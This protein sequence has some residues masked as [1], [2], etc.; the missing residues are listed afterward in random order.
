MPVCE[1]DVHPLPVVISQRLV[2]QDGLSV[3]GG[4]DAVGSG[5]RAFGECGTLWQ[6]ALQERGDTSL[7]AGMT[8]SW[9]WTH[10]DVTVSIGFDPLGEFGQVPIGQDFGPAG[11]VK[12]GLRL[13]IWKFDGDGHSGNL[14]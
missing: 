9:R 13:E 4:F 8:R 3:I 7:A 5:D 10:D 11:N 6:E 1:Q 2:H 14:H 12:R